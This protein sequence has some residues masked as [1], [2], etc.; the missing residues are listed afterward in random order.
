M[1]MTDFNRDGLTDFVIGHLDAPTALLENQTVTQGNH[2]MLE[3][4]GTASERDATGAKVSVTVA[5]SKIVQWVTAGDGY[6]CSDE[7]YL[8]LATGGE[9]QIEAIE[10]VW[11][12]GQISAFHNVEPN[13]RYLI[14]EGRPELI[15]RERP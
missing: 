2:L 7:A 12:S 3:L 15:R 6:F 4:V 11:P 13:R 9:S 8:D 5:D 1:V 14:I 10:V